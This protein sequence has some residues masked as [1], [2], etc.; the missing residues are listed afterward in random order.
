[1]EAPSKVAVK[2]WNDP[3]FIGSLWL[4]TLFM[5]GGFFFF[6]LLPRAAVSYGEVI[7]ATKSDLCPGDLLEYSVTVEINHYPGE[8]T[9]SESWCRAGESG[10][11]ANSLAK[12]QTVPLADY[13]LIHGTPSV[14]IPVSR[15][16]TA[17]AYEY[18]HVAVNGKASGYIVPFTIRADCPAI[19]TPAP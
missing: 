13:R 6:V 7:P 15:F 14:P 17:G 9:I 3:R 19:P 2:M 8:A 1:M 16:F 12:T 18:W 10:P 4:L 11:C 5:F